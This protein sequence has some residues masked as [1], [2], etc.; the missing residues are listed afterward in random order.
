V[1]QKALLLYWPLSLRGGWTYRSAAEVM[2]QVLYP[3][4]ALKY[5]RFSQY[6]SLTVGALLT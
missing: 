6:I 3:S 2:L 5:L 1:E 4:K